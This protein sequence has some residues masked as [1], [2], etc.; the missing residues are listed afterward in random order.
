MYDDTG[1][2]RAGSSVLIQVHLLDIPLCRLVHAL[3]MSCVWMKLTHALM[4]ASGS[5]CLYCLR[6]ALKYRK[7]S[8]G[9][10]RSCPCCE[11]S[12]PL[13]FKP[14]R[15]LLSRKPP[16]FFHARSCMLQC[17][18]VATSLALQPGQRLIKVPRTDADSELYHSHDSNKRIIGGND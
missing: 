1:R 13:Y 17:D 12:S 10:A 18:R 4:I 5:F 8:L 3:V 9:I 14:P 15:Q 6:R 2:T 7:I 11:G 16:T